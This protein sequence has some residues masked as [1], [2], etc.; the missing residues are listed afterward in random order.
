MIYTKKGH[1]NTTVHVNNSP[2]TCVLRLC[3]A[4]FE[5]D[6]GNHIL[7]SIKMKAKLVYGQDSVVYFWI[8][9]EYLVCT[10]T[11]TTAF[12]NLTSQNLF[13]AIN[14]IDCTMRSFYCQ[15]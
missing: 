3:S 5:P 6:N 7:S 8:T 12:H 13:S 2:Y 15:C 11:T 9:Y 4:V 1:K 14:H 10:S